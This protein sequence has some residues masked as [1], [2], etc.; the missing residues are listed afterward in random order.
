MI[1]GYII[2]KCEDGTDKWLRCNARLC[3]D[4]HYKVIA[5]F[6]FQAVKYA[7]CQFVQFVLSFVLIPLPHYIVLIDFCCCPRYLD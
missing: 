2:Q 7:C 5:T 4:L 6:F 1:T 3:Q